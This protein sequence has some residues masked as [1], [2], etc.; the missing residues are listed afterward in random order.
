VSGRVKRCP[1]LSTSTTTNKLNSTKLQ[2]TE[3][4]ISER[5]F[6]TEQT[7]MNKNY[8]K[9]TKRSENLFIHKDKNYIKEYIIYSFTYFRKKKTTKRHYIDFILF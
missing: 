9:G 7:K 1:Y 8:K 6:N 5:S 4:L 2:K 3:K